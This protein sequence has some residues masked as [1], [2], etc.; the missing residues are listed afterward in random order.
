[1]HKGKPVILC[2]DD[3]DDV[4]ATL[5]IVLERNNFVCVDAST[6]EEGLAKFKEQAPDLIIVDLMMEEV[7]AGTSFVK[8]IRAAGSQVPIYMLSSVGDQLNLSADYAALGLS[9]VF[10]KP[11]NPDVLLK[12][13]RTRLG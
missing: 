6:A 10:Q 4:L 7:D 11:V 13:L 1:M 8:E 9:G 12:T 2:I 5:R 3:D